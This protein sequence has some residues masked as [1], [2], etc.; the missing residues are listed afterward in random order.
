MQKRK[1]IGGLEYFVSKLD[2]AEERLQSAVTALENAVRDKNRK[3]SS[4]FSNTGDMDLAAARAKARELEAL[5]RAAVERIE[6]AILRVKA[7]I[8]T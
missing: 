3:Q 4:A 5:Q 8:G 1:K 2:E 6:A 7:I